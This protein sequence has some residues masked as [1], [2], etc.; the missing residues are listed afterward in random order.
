MVLVDTSVWLRFLAGKQPYA[1]EL[2]RLLQNDEVL[3]HELI[4]GELLVGDLGARR[5]LLEA[6]TLIHYA[7]VVPHGEVVLFVTQRKLHGRGLG[8]IDA[9]LLASAVV[10]G[11]R[12]WTADKALAHAASALGVAYPVS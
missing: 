12:L 9:H 8:W 4:Q 1:R 6:Y 10:A 5:E 7:A 2:D 3:G 11:S